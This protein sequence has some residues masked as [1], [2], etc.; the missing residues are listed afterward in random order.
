MPIRAALLA[1]AVLVAS[2]LPATAGN[3]VSSSTTTCTQK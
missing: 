3:C 1:F 2:G